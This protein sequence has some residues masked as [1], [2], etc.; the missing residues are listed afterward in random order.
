MRFIPCV[1]GSISLF[2]LLQY[3][4]IVGAHHSSFI[5]STVEEH[6][7]CFQFGDITDSCMRP[8]VHNVYEFLLGE[9]GIATLAETVNQF[10]KVVVT[11]N[12][13][14]SHV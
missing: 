5:H 12:T 3:I 4:Y 11:D 10:L 6:F 2:S 1:A 9:S 14:T 13:P 8:L 7:K